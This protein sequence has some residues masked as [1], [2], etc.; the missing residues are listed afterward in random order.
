MHFHL[1][2]N[3]LLMRVLKFKVDIHGGQ[4]ID[5]WN[6]GHHLHEKSCE[7]KQDS[8]WATAAQTP[9]QQH[10]PQQLSGHTVGHQAGECSS[11]GQHHNLWVEC[12]VRGE[13]VLNHPTPSAK[14]PESETA[15]CHLI[16]SLHHG[17]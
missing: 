11:L 6:R 3:C 8:S 13:N 14:P 16:L 1:P 12:L 10:K 7:G 17:N 9:P 5:W 2:V 15:G 4:H